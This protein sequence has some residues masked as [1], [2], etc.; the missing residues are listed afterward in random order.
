MDGEKR[1]IAVIGAT[2]SV[3]RAVLDVCASFPEYFNVWALAANSNVDGLLALG[4]AFKSQLLVLSNPVAANFLNEKTPDSICCLGG[5]NGVNAIIEDPRCDEVVFASS[6]TDALPALIKA[7]ELHRKVY[8]ANKEIIVAAGE[9]FTLLDKDGIIP[10]DS[11]H[12]AVWQ[13]L[14]CEKPDR[15]N[16]IFLT[17][18]GGPFLDTPLDEL[19]NVTFQQ[20]ASHPV[21]PM[22]KKIS[23]DSATLMNKGIE[24]IEAHYLFSLEPEKINAVIHPQA[25]V[26]AFVE[27]VDGAVKMLFSKPDM[28]V[29]ILSA[30]GFPYR[31]DNPFESLR[32]PDLT[33]LSLHFR[34]PDK[35]KFPCLAIATEACRLGGAYPA[36]LIGADEGVVSLFMN[37]K[38]GFM[39]IPVRIEEIL[40]SYKGG[41][42]CSWEESLSLVDEAIALSSAF[43]RSRKKHFPM[44]GLK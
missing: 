7:L 36:L 35:K 44:E 11:E 3:G 23:I 13:C 40:S 4:Y 1:N 29:S 2:G 9:W 31:F 15:V 43:N 39:E 25:L 20:A 28:R 8:L 19:E 6:G 26:H 22:G 10:L 16:N 37:G 30:L 14:M 17:A 42:P 5:I 12:N 21:W 32:P 18:S 41:P 38:I 27:F 33:Q 24:M 34:P